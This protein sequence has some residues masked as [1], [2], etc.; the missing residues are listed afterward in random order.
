MGLFN[1]ELGKKLHYILHND[2]AR[3][4]WILLPRG[5]SGC[6]AAVWWFRLLLS[7][8]KYTGSRGF[9]GIPTTIST[10]NSTTCISISPTSTTTT[11]YTTYTRNYTI[12]TNYTTYTRNYTIPTNYTTSTTSTTSRTT[13]ISVVEWSRKGESHGGT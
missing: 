13:T 11:N 4:L 2:K 10:T 12:T 5:S 6:S 1:S 9:R 3:Y 7:T 8:T